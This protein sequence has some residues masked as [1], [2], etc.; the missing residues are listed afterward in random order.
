MDKSLKY[1]NFPPK[2]QWPLGTVP[3]GSDFGL[4]S[5][6]KTPSVS[7]FFFIIFHFF[8]HYSRVFCFPF[9]IT[10]LETCQILLVFAPNLGKFPL[11]VSPSP[12]FQGKKNL[13]FYFYSFLILRRFSI[14][15]AILPVSSRLF[16]FNYFL[17]FFL[18]FYPSLGLGPSVRSPAPGGI[19]GKKRG[20]RAGK[21][22][23]PP[24][25]P[26]G[27]RAKANTKNQ[28][29]R[30]KI[31]YPPPHTLQTHIFCEVHVKK[32]QKNKKMT[33]PLSDLT[34]VCHEDFF[35]CQKREN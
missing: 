14:L 16:I 28:G 9:S 2:K 6:K 11:S 25:F 24:P 18:H 7:H 30:R 19:G 13:K 1:P 31:H 17:F 5:P 22:K 32:R 27:H 23:S 15:R 33:S 34:G 35:S 10:G 4:F 3:C 21:K 12:P 20:F 26:T 8:L 29:K